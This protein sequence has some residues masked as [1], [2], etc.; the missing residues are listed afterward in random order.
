MI[1]L[2]PETIFCTLCGTGY[3]WEEANKNK[4]NPEYYK[5]MNIDGRSIDFYKLVNC[6]HC[7]GGMHRNI[8]YDKL[9]ILHD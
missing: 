2:K 6:P 9:G 7:G 3:S 4:Y 1:N 5:A 8:F